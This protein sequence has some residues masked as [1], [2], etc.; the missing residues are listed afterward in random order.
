MSDFG[1][2]RSLTLSTA[3]AVS[4]N[5]NSMLERANI[6]RYC[7]AKCSKEVPLGAE[8]ITTFDGGAG[9]KYINAR[10]TMPTTH[11]L[12]ANP[13]NS[14]QRLYP[15]MNI[16]PGS[17][18]AHGLT[19]RAFLIR[20]RDI[21]R[22]LTSADCLARV[23][24]FYGVISAPP[25][26]ADRA[27]DYNSFRCIQ[28]GAQC[29]LLA[30]SGHRVAYRTSRCVLAF[31]PLLRGLGRGGTCGGAISSQ[32]SLVRQLRGRSRRARSRPVGFGGSVCS[33]VG[34][35]PI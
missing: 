2:C 22:A 19:E 28:N 11:K 8:A 12:A 6:S 5:S 18:S 34:P 3:P 7:L 21:V 10:E 29:P 30:Q 13:L 4:R 14:C 31:D 9:M 20:Q 23:H 17:P 35:R 27:K 15:S 24:Q 16:S 1:S 32:Q 26:R 25:R 33:W